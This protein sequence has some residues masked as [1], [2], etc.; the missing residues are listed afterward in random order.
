MYTF[1]AYYMGSAQQ[2]L[3]YPKP[4]RDQAYKSNFFDIS[5]IT[6]AWREAEL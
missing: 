2:E 5:T 3:N 4:F 6:S 1:I